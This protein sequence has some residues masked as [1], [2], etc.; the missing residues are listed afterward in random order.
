MFGRENP[1]RFLSADPQKQLLLTRRLQAV[2]L[3]FASCCLFN[4]SG[5]ERLETMRCFMRDLL[6][7]TCCACQEIMDQ[8]VGEKPPPV[9]E[10][11]SGDGT[12]DGSDTGD[13]SG[14]GKA[15]R[16]GAGTPEGRGEDAAEI[17]GSEDEEDDP[18]AGLEGNEVDSTQSSRQESWSAEASEASKAEAPLHPLASHHRAPDAR[19]APGAQHPPPLAPSL[20]TRDRAIGTWLEAAG[21]ACRC[22]A[23]LRWNAQLNAPPCLSAGRF[24]ARR[25][26]VP[27]GSGPGLT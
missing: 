12:G 25:P 5:L 21:M 14:S 22:S 15:V 17:Q 13:G 20:A 7:L 1:L 4:S 8:R 19:G 27:C 10:S 2:V 26:F 6:L 11:D 9:G 24:G 23:S 3:S 18:V 16:H